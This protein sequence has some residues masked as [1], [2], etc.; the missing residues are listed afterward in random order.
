MATLLRGAFPGYSVNKFELWLE[1][2][3]SGGIAVPENRY[4]RAKGERSVA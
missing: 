2:E 4:A 1:S 3:A